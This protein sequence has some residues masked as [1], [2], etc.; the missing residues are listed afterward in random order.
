M[1]GESTCSH[2]VAAVGAVGAA[3]AAVGVVDA[4]AGASFVDK[5]GFVWN[6]KELI[7]SS[8]GNFTNW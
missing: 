8:D 5:Q 7:A 6:L 4:E 3:D 2:V 1:V